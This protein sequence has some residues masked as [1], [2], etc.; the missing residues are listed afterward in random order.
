MKLL[1][2]SS[3]FPHPLDKGDK[4]RLYHQIQHLA[5]EAQITLICMSDIPVSQGSIDILKQF[6][7]TVYIFRISKW[8][9][10]AN[11]IKGLRRGL[12]AQVAY[13][14]NQGIKT[15]ILNI[16][17]QEKPNHIYCQLIRAS[18]YV[19]DVSLPKTLDYMDCLSLSAL[20]RSWQSSALLSRCWRA[21]SRRTRAYELSIYA[22]FNQHTI[23]SAFDAA[24]MPLDPIVQPMHLVTNGLAVDYLNESPKV[25]RDLDILF[26]GNLSYFSNRSAIDYILAQI[27]PILRRK[28][29]NYHMAIAGAHPSQLL[30]AKISRAKVTLLA[31][32]PHAKE[33]YDRA[34]IFLA[35]IYF[36]TGQQNKVLEA[37]ASGCGVICSPE[38]QKGLNLPENSMVHTANTPEEY[39]ILI[40]EKLSNYSEVVQSQGISI[41]RQYLLTHFSWARSAA[42]LIKLFN[43]GDRLNL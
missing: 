25:D 4:L 29:K 42:Q 37:L 19:R 21:E 15:K 43:A 26:L 24:S 6:C 40:I 1:I 31:N 13:F 20:K 9:I 3:R 39:A 36:G 23:I 8:T 14:F 2:I 7:S 38:V 12:P 28:N 41:R 22:S 17:A 30:R 33:V 35:P 27:L 32:V 16:I 10:L 5:A 11:L 18:E 34:K